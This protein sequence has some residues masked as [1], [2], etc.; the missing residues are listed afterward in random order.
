MPPLSAVVW[1]ADRPV[2]APDA[3][4]T[5][6]F[7]SPEGSEVDGIVHLDAQTGELWNET[8]FAWREVGT[9]RWHPLGTAT[10]PGSR[11]VHDVRGLDAGTRIEYRAVTV[12]AADRRTASSTIV[13][14][15]P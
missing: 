5:P 7:T 10:G 14:I 12:D 3:A 9:D 2:T 15:A 4:E 1:V 11:V 6:R 8:S 13:T